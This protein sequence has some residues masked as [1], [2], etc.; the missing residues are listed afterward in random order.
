MAPPRLTHVFGMRCVGIRKPNPGE[1]AVTLSSACGGYRRCKYPTHSYRINI[2]PRGLIKGEI[3]YLMESFLCVP[4]YV[5]RTARLTL[6]CSLSRSPRSSS[7]ASSHPSALFVSRSPDTE[8]LR[9]GVAEFIVG[10]VGEDVAP[11][12]SAAPKVHF[13]IGVCP[14]DVLSRCRINATDFVQ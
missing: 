11:Q 1:S 14:R 13:Q 5:P 10:R 2:R 8:K 9:P 7:L 6:P 12:E 4:C 3:N